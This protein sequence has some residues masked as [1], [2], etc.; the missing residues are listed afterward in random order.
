MS[1]LIDADALLE[2][3]HTIVRLV[4][5]G[6]QYESVIY[7]EEIDDAPIVDA[8]PVVRCKDCIYFDPPHIDDHGVRKEYADIP[9]E[10]FSGFG[11]VTMDY[12]I[13]VGGRCCVDCYKGYADDKRVFVSE[14][15]YCGR[16]AKMDGKE[17]NDG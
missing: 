11:L 14:D 15:N 10:A 3:V 9:K 8:V 2:N 4:A 7:A 17:K 12:G 13:N 6:E 5:T 16:G 1:R